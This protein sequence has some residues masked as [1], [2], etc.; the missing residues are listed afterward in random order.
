V[1]DQMT[2]EYSHKRPEMYIEKVSGWNLFSEEVSWFIYDFFRYD[3]NGYEKLLFY[4]YYIN[5]WTL[6]EIAEAA[7]CT[8]QHIGAHIKKIEKKLGHR[9]KNKETWKVAIQ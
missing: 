8:F 9:W 3:L 4:S 1:Q 2:H 7:N 5:G 6:T